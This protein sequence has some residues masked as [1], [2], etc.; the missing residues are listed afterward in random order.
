MILGA[1]LLACWV[2]APLSSA[3]S[4]PEWLSSLVHMDLGHF[5]DGSSVVILS[6]WT[7]FN[8]D[9][10]GKF[11]ETD[12]RAM[13]VLNRRAADR[14][15]DA[16]G[17]ENNDTKVTSI[18]TWAIS[19]SG[20][21]TSSG[22]KD[23]VSAAAIAGFE[24]FDDSRVK[25]VQIPGAE[26]GSLVGYE[27]VTQGRIP[28]KGERFPLEG[29]N[30]VRMSELHVSAPS[31]SLR[32]FVNHPETVSIVSQSPNAAVFRTENRPA[33]P[34]E[35]NSP[36]LSS[37]A[38]G[39]VVNYDPKGATALQSW[40]DAGRDYHVLFDN[41]EKPEG[42]IA[43]EVNLLSAGHSSDLDKIDAL[44]TFV[45]RQIRYVAI[46]IGIG[47]YQPHP[48]ADVF[49]YRY[50]DCKD[51]ANLLISMLSKI[52]IRGYPALVGTRGGVEADP[53][54]PTL[55]TFD[56]MIVALPVSD[57]LRATVAGF[58]AYDSKT[59]I[60]WIDPTSETNPIGQLPEMDQGVFALVAYPDRGDLLRIPETPPE[61]N[62]VQYSAHVSLRPDGKGT[63]N[64]GVK[65]LGATSAREH[66]FYRG[67]SQGDILKV[68][69]RRVSNFVSEASFREATISGIEDS[70][71]QVQEKYSFAGD[72]SSASSGD[73]WFLQPLF[74]SG[75]GIPEIG[76]RPRKLPMDI[77]PP[78]Q[79]RGEYRLELPAGMKID[80]IP[81]KTSAQS[82][83]GELEVTYSLEG[84]VLTAKEVLSF[85]KS[86]ISPEEYPSFREFVNS[87]FRAEKARLR[88]VK[89][90]S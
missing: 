32:W 88:V 21:V 79:I 24:L 9:A 26:E 4:V 84:N 86:R 85:T 67:L 72:F 40:Q 30:P 39:V 54:I 29:M 35:A 74:L 1:F 2:G 76:P 73:S 36:P 89:S 77:G 64:V 70:A 19:P 15:L 8:V 55:A 87:W 3:D 83:F 58:P 17:R 13:R 44:Y 61:M 37:I 65:Y 50:G 60:L 82:E 52:G 31:G 48:A 6:D 68:F 66:G 45:S 41:G 49:K 51:K 90:A 71:Q 10:S 43:S 80:R 12:R 56:H 22:K 25:V 16:V 27:V 11:V 69:E 5:G 28:I 78:F 23:V 47:G 63:A 46:E 53:A 57:S 18:Q 62:G 75:I 38:A 7:E 14:F 34:E 33:L 81:N 42:E 59:K 20:H